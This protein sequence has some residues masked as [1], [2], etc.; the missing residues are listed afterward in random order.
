MERTQEQKNRAAME[1]AT[2]VAQLQCSVA[3]GNELD[4]RDDVIRV[5]YR[6]GDVIE[7]VFGT[8]FAGLDLDKLANDLTRGR[9][10]P[11]AVA[12]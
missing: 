2:R 8:E 7:E 5:A 1:L 10:L 9:R 3:N 4:V 6:L 12:A 11:K